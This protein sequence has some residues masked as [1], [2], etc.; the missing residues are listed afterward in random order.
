LSTLLAVPLRLTLFGVDDD[1]KLLDSRIALLE[2]LRRTVNRLTLYCERGQIAAERT[3]ALATLLEPMVREVAVDAGSF[4]AKVWLLRYV[5]ISDVS[6]TTPV[7]LRLGIPSRNVT[8]D[9]SWDVALVLDGY[10]T[11]RVKADNRPLAQLLMWLAQRDP[12]LTPER[13]EQ[14][15]LLR[16]EASRTDWDYPP[17][18]DSLEFAVS[19]IGRR[20]NGW[21]LLPGARRLAVI[22]PFL[23]GTALNQLAQAAAPGAPLT[24][25]SRADELSALPAAFGR[26]RLW[27]PHVLHQGLFDEPGEDP[28]SSSG[29]ATGE[30]H[31]KIYLGDYAAGRGGNLAIVVGSANATNAALVDQRNV[32]IMV[33]LTGRRGALGNIEDLLGPTALGRYLRD[34]EWPAKPTNST[35]SPAEQKLDSARQSLLDAKWK[36]R[37]AQAG[38][39]EWSPFLSSSSPVQ[40]PT[41]VSCTVRLATMPE[42]RAIGL[43]ADQKST[44]LARCATAD[45]TAFVAFALSIEGADD[46]RL[47]LNLPDA[48]MPDGRDSAVL[49]SVIS[50]SQAFLSYLRFLL[51]DL[52]GIEAFEE[53]LRANKEVPGPAADSIATVPLLED[54]VRALSQAPERL[55]AIQRLMRQVAADGEL[56]AI[57]PAGFEA[58]WARFTPLIAEGTAQ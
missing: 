38:V 12:S 21:P 50:N 37:F 2:A 36:L 56:R 13:R 24:L 44:A 25:V 42:N 34:F 22:S 35:L 16:D 53:L 5:A 6:D 46:V 51:G 29:A 48:E 47:V 49:R 1:E 19:G 11:G 43:S 30:L 7:L 9:R 40:F 20:I 28:A 26:E 14:I 45:A 54:L 41:S 58:L 55:V 8:L 32:E 57:V 31:A 39:K 23:R 10:P 18:I 17:G 15:E 3:S 52:G 27:R 4:H 33:R